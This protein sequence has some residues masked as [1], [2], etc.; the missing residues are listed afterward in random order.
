MI[1][2]GFSEVLITAVDKYP[3]DA[4]IKS[5]CIGNLMKSSSQ[6][7]IKDSLSLFKGIEV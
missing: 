2:S 6:E 7:L 4:I 1:H 3:A 5:R